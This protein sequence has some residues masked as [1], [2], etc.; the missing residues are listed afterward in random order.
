MRLNV[1]VY[2]PLTTP[3]RAINGVSWQ[4]LL[5]DPPLVIVV[6]L[7]CMQALALYCDL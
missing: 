5:R 2:Q 1:I 7:S 6:I 4:M 3:I